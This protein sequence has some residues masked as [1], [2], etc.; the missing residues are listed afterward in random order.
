MTILV[1]NIAAWQ[2]RILNRHI[3]SPNL[4]S[5]METSLWLGYCLVTVK[6]GKRGWA[7]SYLWCV[8]AITVTI[9]GARHTSSPLE[10]AR[11]LYWQ[12]FALG[13]TISMKNTFLLLTYT[14]FR[15][16]TVNLTWLFYL[17]SFIL[18]T[19]WANLSQSSIKRQ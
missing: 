4:E 7:V 12:I 11:S 3:L 15:Q 9:Q 14:F 10:E 6:L 5:E 17:H 18:I 16:L 2:A 13:S 8:D 1:Q 19:F